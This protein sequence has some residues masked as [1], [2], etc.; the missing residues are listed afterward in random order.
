MTTLDIVLLVPFL[1]AAFK[2]ITKGFLVQAGTLVAF[3]LG[4]FLAVRFSDWF[5]TFLHEHSSVSFKV[6]QY[7]SFALLFLGVMVGMYFLTRILESMLKNLALNWVNRL[8]GLVFSLFKMALFIS[9]LI[10]LFE[11]LN[12][13]V[14]VS[15][16]HKPPQSFLYKIVQPV[17]PATFNFFGQHKNEM[18]DFVHEHT[19]SK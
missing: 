12:K 11:A 5:S 13:R 18:K 17:A 16:N 6:A 1:Y 4:L 10:Y 7:V 14:Q 8:A 3:V 15:D 19:K 2:G 9:T